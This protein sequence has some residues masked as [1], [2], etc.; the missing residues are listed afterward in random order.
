MSGVQ[1]QEFR[2]RE[3]TL[4]FKTA[5]RHASAERSETSSVWVAAVGDGIEGFGESCPRP[6]VTGESIETARAFFAEHEASVR[7]RVRDVMS[8]KAWMVEHGDEIDR[9]PAAWCA[10]ELATLDLMARHAGLAIELFLGLPPLAGRFH[11]SAVLGDMGPDAFRAMAGRYRALGFTDF[12]VK[13]SG[14]LVRDREKL[15]L[16]LEQPGVRIRVDANNLWQSA[17]EAVAFLDALGAPLFAVEE[18]IAPGRFDLLASIARRLGCRIVLDESLSRSAQVATLAAD[19]A[20]WLINLRVSKMGGLLRSLAVADAARAAGVGLIVGAQVGETSLLTR[21]AL[22]VAHASRDILVAQ[23]GA[24]GTLL[25]E[26]DVCDPP[27]MFGPGGVLETEAHAMLAGPGFGLTP[28]S[29]FAVHAP[30]R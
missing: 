1:L 2:F 6:Y 12:K 16:L 20:N 13:V 21:A 17:D 5:F 19:P 18:P 27:L 28:G 22:T 8:L 25:L 14:D 4:P 11:Y 24:F 7:A 23:E 10:I 30:G 15:A 9:H 29:A 26:R 3:L